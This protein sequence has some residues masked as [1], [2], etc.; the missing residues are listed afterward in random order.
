MYEVSIYPAK[1]DL[2]K[3]V[4]STDVLSSRAFSDLPSALKFQDYFREMGYI[5]L[6]FDHTY[7]EIFSQSEEEQDDEFYESFACY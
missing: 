7:D 3:G 6:M 2:Q 4:D 1:V 5:V